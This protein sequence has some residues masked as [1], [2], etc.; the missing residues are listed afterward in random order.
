MFITDSSCHWMWL[1][2]G[3]RLLIASGKALVLAQQV[4]GIP[5]CCVSVT[6]LPW[7]SV[8]KE[9]GSTTTSS[10]WHYGR[11]L[12]E[13]EKSSTVQQRSESAC[14]VLSLEKQVQPSALRSVHR[15]LYRE[16]YS[17]EAL[18]WMLPK[19]HLWRSSDCIWS[20]RVILCLQSGVQWT[21]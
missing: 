1:S 19:L 16:C 15:H 17:R 8:K 11:F 7:N 21:S 3:V 18:T 2:G 10:Q 5:V 12:W 20:V 6:P 4:T 13:P 9:R 14:S